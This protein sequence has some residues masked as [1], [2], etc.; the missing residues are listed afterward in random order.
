MSIV[1][2]LHVFLDRAFVEWMF[3]R[4]L[5]GEEVGYVVQLE[6]EHLPASVVV[7]VV[8]LSG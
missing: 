1:S 6:L 4:K 2:F 3:F 7:T 5:I 8:I